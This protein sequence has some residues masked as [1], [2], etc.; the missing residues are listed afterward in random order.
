[1]RTNDRPRT[2][3]TCAFRFDA[4]RVRSERWL[5]ELCA[6]CAHDVWEAESLGELLEMSGTLPG[7]DDDQT[8]CEHYVEV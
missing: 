3:R 8:A 2:C 7:V 4:V 1:M 6:V 5:G